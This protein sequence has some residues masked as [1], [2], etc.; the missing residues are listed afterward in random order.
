MLAK[1]AAFMLF[2]VFTADT[3][4]RF[5]RFIFAYLDA[6][7]EFPKIL[8]VAVAAVGDTYSGYMLFG[9]IVATLLATTAGIS[10]VF[11]LNTLVFFAL[12]ITGGLV[13]IAIL[14]WV[15]IPWDLLLPLAIASFGTYI[16]S[17]VFCEI[18][19]ALDIYKL[20]TNQNGRKI[21]D[22]TT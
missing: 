9:I 18:Y 21:D 19:A 8:G 20:V 5:A 12:N 2:G 16:L 17:S 1:Y 14:N 13:F 22:S 4:F 15:N 3:A 10:H 6:A 7:E 11:Q